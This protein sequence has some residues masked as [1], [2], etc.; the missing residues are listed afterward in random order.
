MGGAVNADPVANSAVVTNPAG[1]ARTYVYAAEATFHRQGPGDRNAAGLVRQGPGD[2]SAAGLVVVDTKTQPALGV[3]LSYAY[4]FTDPKSADEIDGHNGR[5]AFSHAVVPNQL[6]MGVGLHYLHFDRTGGL[7][8]LKAFTLD[9]GALVSLSSNL[10]LGLVGNNLIDV[11]DDEA[12]VMAGGGF[13]Y[14]GQ[15]IVIDAETHF[16]F[17]TRDAPSPVY[18]AGLELVVAEMIPLRAGFE[19]NRA[20]KQNIASGG[21]G[22]LTGG[23]G[24]QGS[25]F[26]IGFRKTLEVKQGLHFG[27][28][29]MVFL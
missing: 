28:G 11:D 6:Y 8:D 19:A 24:S 17:S 20:T 27:A 1:I 12:P 3:G 9:A 21:L 7:S 15:S 14:T 23:A 4:E 18:K 16:D 22:F 29:L 26:H 10:H 13:A 25:Q 5:L 2:R